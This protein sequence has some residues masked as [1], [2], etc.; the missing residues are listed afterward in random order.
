[1]KLRKLA[2]QNIRSFMERQE[3]LLDGNISILI[4]PNGGGKTNL[5]DAAVVML[6]RFLFASMY[7]A[8]SPT[9]ENPE[10]YEFRR[11]DALDVL[12]LEKHSASKSGL[13]Q[14]VE[15]EVEVTTRD[16]EN[17]RLMKEGAEK[18][19]SLSA[20][21]Y[22]NVP[23]AN[24]SKWK[25]DNLVDGQRF[26]YQLVNGNLQHDG[27]EEAA[28]FLQYLNIFEIDSYLREEYE[29]STLSTPMIYLPVNRTASGFHSSVALASYNQ[30]EQKR[31]ADAAW[32]K[33]GTSIVALAVGR[34]AQKY[35]L[36]LEK[37]KGIASKEFYADENLKELTKLLGELGYSWTLE[38]RNPLKNEYDVRLVKQ[39]SSFLVGAASS[40]ER[41]LL[42]YLFAIFALN[43]R[44]ALIVVDEPELHLHPTWQKTLLHMFGRLSET[45]GNQFV[46]ATHSPTFVGPDSI[47]YV[48]RVFS[49]DQKSHVLRLNIQELP[50]NRHLFNIVNTQ[51]NE[52]LFFADKVVLVEGLSD[53]IF[54]DAVLDAHGRSQASRTTIEV[55]A[56]G[57]KHFFESYQKILRACHIE[58]AIIADLDYIEQIGAQAIKALFV[59]DAK[60]IKKDVIQNEKSGDG[61]ALVASIE[62][63][64]QSG[65][66]DHARSTWEYIKSRRHKLKSELSDEEQ[67]AIDKFIQQKRREGVFVLRK[68]RL[69]DYLPEGYRAKNLDNLI[70]LVAEKDFWS[71]LDADAKAELDGIVK[72]LLATA[73]TSEVPCT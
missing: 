64:I 9:T 41:E 34:L 20:G 13:Q 12:T 39:G 27:S 60:D 33:S 62:K 30:F 19:V 8:H 22:I 70:R 18:V 3:L 44:D 6:R 21:K 61:D 65:S 29:F 4:G 73:D 55:I 15:A 1:M 38:S 53:R 2:V 28:T 5:L 66:W 52:R 50:D 68:G 69:E 42:T 25:L 63:A 47:Q 67:A 71:K 46:L 59:V 16:I 31:Q 32:S 23:L 57:G 58:H 43:V 10:R 17:M 26:L 7:A 11:N 14:I 35:R 72:A 40:G 56:V 51:N 49:R 45:T 24:A 37:D 54:F 36:L 48:S